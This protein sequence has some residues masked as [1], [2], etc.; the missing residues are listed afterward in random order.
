MIHWTPQ[1]SVMSE[2]H[3]LLLQFVRLYKRERVYRKAV[4]VV[5]QMLGQ[6]GQSA[7]AIQVAD[8]IEAE[9]PRAQQDVDALFLSL[10]TS[11]AAG[12]PYL[13]ILRSLLEK[14]K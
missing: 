1:Q 13:P 5:L 10:E 11:L 14:L 3:E 8:A 2:T 7:L 12:T 4:L 6:V 9:E